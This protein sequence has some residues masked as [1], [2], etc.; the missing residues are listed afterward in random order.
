MNQKKEGVGERETP[1][2]E[3][4]RENERQEEKKV[5]SEW[6]VRLIVL[7][8][9]ASKLPCSDHSPSA[10]AR[11]GLHNY[12]PPNPHPHGVGA[13]A[14]S[15]GRVLMRNELSGANHSS[16]WGWIQL[17]HSRQLQPLPA[18]NWQLEFLSNCGR[19]GPQQKEQRRRKRSCLR[20]GQKF[21]L[22]VCVCVSV[23]VYVCVCVCV[24]VCVM[25]VCVCVCI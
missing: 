23:N 16:G 10:T 8:G 18:F 11:A 3:E 25:Q 9:M 24:Y 13:V 5:R 21:F 19:L 15:K 7:R 17:C 22:C 6:V 1:P 4:E 14:R 12:H 20:D 2:R